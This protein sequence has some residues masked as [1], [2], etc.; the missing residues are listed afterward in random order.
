MGGGPDACIGRLNLRFKRVR[1][2]SAEL[3][4]EAAIEALGLLRCQ[5]RCFDVEKARAALAHLATI[6]SARPKH[7]EQTTRG[8]DPSGHHALL[9]VFRLHRTCVQVSSTFVLIIT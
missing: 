3:L 7:A 1:R 4:S 5:R 2:R 8:S 6:V 9:C